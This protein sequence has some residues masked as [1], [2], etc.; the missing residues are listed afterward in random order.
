MKTKWFDDKN[1]T[2]L[3]ICAGKG[4]RILPYSKEIPKAMISLNKKPILHYVIDYWKEY[5]KNFVFIVGYQKNHIIN[6]AKKLP[7]QSQFVEQKELKGIANAISLAKEL[8]SENFI[9]VLGDCICTGTFS[10]PDIM[11]QGIGIWKTENQEYIKN[12]YAVIVEK[13]KVSKVIEKPKETYNNLCGMGVYFFNKKIFNY[14]D[15]TPPS[16]LRNEIEITD[17]IQMMINADEKITPIYFNG[18]YINITFPKDLEKAQKLLT[19][20]L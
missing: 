8:V 1:L 4:T 15:M 17:V 10:S 18:E 20:T 11:T 12:N 5:T 14:I 9:V 7:I 19:K 16:Q 13:D 6:Y 2:C 3:V